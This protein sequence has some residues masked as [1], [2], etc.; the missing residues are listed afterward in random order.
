MKF[1]RFDTDDDST[2][3]VEIND[4][5]DGV[6][7]SLINGLRRL[8]INSVPCI[9]FHEKDVTIVQNSSFMHNTS[10]A[11][12]IAELVLD[13]RHEM[14]KVGNKFRLKVDND[15]SLIKSVTANNIIAESGDSITGLMAQPDSFI[16]QLRPGETVEAEMTL[17]MGTGYMNNAFYQTACCSSYRFKSFDVENGSD[18]EAAKRYPRSRYGWPLTIQFSVESFGHHP[19]KEIVL[20]ATDI[21]KQKIV[22]LRERIEN[23][24]ADSPEI[25]VKVSG[26]RAEIIYENPNGINRNDFA[27]AG[28][29]PEE[30][31]VANMY[32]SEGLRYLWGEVVPSYGDD[33]NE[34]REIF[35]QQ[36][37]ISFK[38]YHPLTTKYMLICQLPDRLQALP[39]PMPQEKSLPIRFIIQTLNIAIRKCEEMRDSIENL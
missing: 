30:Y 3:A 14:C 7:P 24:S 39:D 26:N 32:L 23:Y 15:D 37:E 18:L 6:N 9:A 22:S 35:S 13:N 27:P 34:A 8:V 1:T 4:D 16:V 28:D 17:S 38:R 11:H 29:F 33:L 12:R 19:V 2:I 36:S 25:N 31:A 20:M 10:L 5:K 21:F